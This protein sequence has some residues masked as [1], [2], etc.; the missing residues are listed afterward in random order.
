MDNIF[1]AVMAACTSLF[2]D[3]YLP[4]RQ[5]NIVRDHDQL[6]FGIDLVVIC[7]R[8]DA[9]PASVHKGNGFYQNH[10]LS[11]NDSL[12]RQR[13]VLD[14]HHRNIIFLCQRVYHSKSGIMPGICI[15]FSRISKPRYYKH[16]C[17]PFS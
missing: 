5:V 6:T 7:Q 9:F 13:P 8:A 12:S 1:Q 4:R 10:F 15:F 11:V 17:F 2:P 3:T 14:T 16:S